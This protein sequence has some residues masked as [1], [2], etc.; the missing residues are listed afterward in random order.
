MQCRG[1]RLGPL[2][3][4]FFSWA[5]M[6]RVQIVRTGDLVRGLG[7]N[8][9]QEADLFK[10][11][12]RGGRVVQLMRGLYLVPP[13]LPPGGK[14][15]PS[16]LLI[17]ATFMRE[18]G[19]KYQITGPFAFNARGLSYQVP[20]ETCV[21]NT[22]LSGRREIAGLPFLFIKVAEN[23]LGAEESVKI[24][25]TEETAL[26]SSLPRAVFDAIYD[27]SRFGSLPE[28]CS[29]IAERRKDKAF[30]KDLVDV[31]LRFGNVST[32]RRLGCWLEMLAVDPAQVRRLLR[33]V[34]RTTAFIPLAPG[35]KASG[36]T[37]SKWGVLVNYEVADVQAA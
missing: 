14:W 4:R 34:K 33:S 18:L 11:M 8:P 36:R 19:A 32:R 17:V 3:T 13:R 27:Y 21:Y 6:R 28:A 2:E 24:E 29:W 1:W 20:V 12:R 15:V 26:L 23:N 31:T 9:Q 37:D 10:N 25:G 5:Q 22:A 35:R 30:I 16:P 7:I